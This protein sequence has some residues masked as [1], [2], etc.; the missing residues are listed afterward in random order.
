[1][2]NILEEKQLHPQAYA[3]LQLLYGKK[4]KGWVDFFGKSLYTIKKAIFIWPTY[5]VCKCS[6]RLWTWK[7][8]KVEAQYTEKILNK[9]E[10]SFNNN[11][12]WWKSMLKRFKIYFSY[13]RGLKKVESTSYA[14][15]LIQPNWMKSKPYTQTKKYPPVLLFIVIKWPLLRG[16]KKY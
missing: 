3:F 7:S 12:A 1:M 5:Y 6:R 13:N 10:N 9:I 15:R 4:S 16:F 14:A 8:W 11:F 2:R